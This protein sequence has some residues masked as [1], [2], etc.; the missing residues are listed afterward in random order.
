M[1][2][3][4]NA[5]LYEKTIYN[6]GHI[7]RSLLFNFYHFIINH[8]QSQVLSWAFKGI[9]RTSSG[10]TS[11]LMQY[12]GE[13]ECQIDSLKKSLH[14]TVFLSRKGTYR[15]SCWQAVVLCDRSIWRK[16]RTVDH[17][18]SMIGNHTLTTAVA[19]VEVKVLPL[20]Y[21]CFHDRCDALTLVTKLLFNS[22]FSAYGFLTVLSKRLK[23]D[24]QNIHGL[25]TY[26][27]S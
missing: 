8:K 16:P 26:H 23:P 19:S 15:C 18:C 9:W 4:L 3:N 5:E 12:L 25:L 21:P 27:F 24:V 11:M 13:V 20:R 17:S 14:T 10:L 22:L 6:S 1:L 2:C 7:Q